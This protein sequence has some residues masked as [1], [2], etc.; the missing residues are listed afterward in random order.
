ML[1]FYMNNNV[2]IDQQPIDK[3][4]IEENFKIP[5]DKEI[6]MKMINDILY[7]VIDL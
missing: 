1:E 7:I 2:E 4:V 6:Q 3:Q 5:S